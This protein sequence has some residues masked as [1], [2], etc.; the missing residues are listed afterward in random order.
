MEAEVEVEEEMIW[1]RNREGD[2]MRDGNFTRKIEV[3]VENSSWIL[4]RWGSFGLGIQP[5]YSTAI[6]P[7]TPALSIRTSLTAPTTPRGLPFRSTL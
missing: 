7:S 6:S 2:V 3:F 5:S 1:C 4:T